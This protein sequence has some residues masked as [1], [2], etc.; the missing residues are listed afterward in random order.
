[1]CFAPFRLLQSAFK[2]MIVSRKRSCYERLIVQTV[3]KTFVQNITH[4]HTHIKHVQYHNWVFYHHAKRVYCFLNMW[5]AHVLLCL[6]TFQY[7]QTFLSIFVF[8]L[9]YWVL[10]LLLVQGWATNELKVIINKTFLMFL[11]IINVRQ[12][13]STALEKVF[14]L[15]NIKKCILWMMHNWHDYPRNSK[16]CSQLK[17]PRKP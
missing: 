2:I 14:F 15:K 3:I 6:D 8:V 13:N 10:S 16:L 17:R 1:M 4:T 7:T 5:A 11:V 9:C 12:L